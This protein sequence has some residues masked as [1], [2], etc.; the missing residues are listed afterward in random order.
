MNSLDKILKIIR[1]QLGLNISADYNEIHFEKDFQ[2]FSN[3]WKNPN[4]PN[5]QYSLVKKELEAYIS[6]GE[7]TPNMS[8][9]IDLV[10]TT[11]LSNPTLL[12]I[13]CSSGYYNELFQLAGLN[14]NY[15]GCDYSQAFIDFGKKNI[16]CHI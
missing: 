2:K 16:Q 15:Y 12:D 7:T 6:T 3:S 4:I 10:K 14:I 5:Q 9:A 8:S 11:N 13:G 1:N